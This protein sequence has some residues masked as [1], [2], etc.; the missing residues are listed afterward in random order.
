MSEL[1]QISNDFNELTNNPYYIK[2][3]EVHPNINLLVLSL[4][5]A[6]IEQDYNSGSMINPQ[7]FDL[8]YEIYND[9]KIEIENKQILKHKFFVSVDEASVFLKSI[10]DNQRP[11]N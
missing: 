1:K 5:G 10:I 4:R 2:F 3:I 11:M 8:F 6:I 9:L 7:T